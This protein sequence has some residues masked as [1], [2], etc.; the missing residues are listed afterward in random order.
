MSRSPAFLA[1]QLGRA[2]RRRR[3]GFTLVELMVVVAV[4]GI[5][6]SLGIVTFRKYL[7]RSKNVEAIAVMRA[8]AS[9]QERYRGEHMTY[10]NVSFDGTNGDLTRSYPMATANI[11]ATK[12]NWNNNLGNDY[13][14]W[15]VL[16]PTVNQPVQFGYSTVAG[17]PGTTFPTTGF[18]SQ[19]TWPA[20]VNGPW[21][22]VQAR[23][24]PGDTPA[25]VKLMSSYSNVIA[26][27]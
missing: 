27:Q 9:A 15:R 24:N 5:L 19:P 12:Y 13:A 20:T 14:R 7:G 11:G 6:S 8:I 3:L 23:G 16:A 26:E 22:V 2:G 1:S 25:T 18:A 21:Y 4:I 17:L 10:L